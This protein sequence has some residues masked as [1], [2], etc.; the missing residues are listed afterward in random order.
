[1]QTAWA[2][3]AAP[4]SQL[5]LIERFKK[6]LQ[7]RGGRGLIGLRRQFKIFDTNSNGVLEF[8]EFKKAIEDYDIQL[9]PKDVENLFKTFD[10]NGDGV[11]QYDE[12]LKAFI[13]QLPRVRYE[14]VLK[15]FKK[16]DL[17]NENQVSLQDIFATFDAS[18]HPDVLTGKISAEDANTDFQETF[19]MHHNTI[20][21]YSPDTP[22]SVDEFLEFYAYMSTMV[23][24]DHV[25]DQLLTGPWNL[26][27]MMQT[28]YAGTS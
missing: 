16:L 5:I 13:G 11:I 17:Y 3:K 18:R 23:D 20:H 2:R 14:L 1:M 22:V 10:I 6:E 19:T 27:S 8:F 25:F 7:D 28:Y 24:T 26:D 9:H 12:F 15:A 4:K 21:D